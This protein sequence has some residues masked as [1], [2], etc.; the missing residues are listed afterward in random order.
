MTVNVSDLVL[1]DSEPTSETDLWE[2]ASVFVADWT[3]PVELTNS[4]TTVIHESRTA[5]E[6]RIGLSNKPRK[7][8][9]SQNKIF[10]SGDVSDIKTIMRRV[11]ESR[12]LTPM[13]CDPCQL[14]GI[15]NPQSA[16]GPTW[17]IENAT[18]SRISK[19]GWG[20]LGKK[21]N[22]TQFS[23]YAFCGDFDVNESAGSIQFCNDDGGCC[24]GDMFDGITY[25]QPSVSHSGYSTLTAIPTSGF[26][27]SATMDTS[28][29]VP[30]NGDH[31]ILILNYL[32]KRGESLSTG[33]MQLVDSNGRTVLGPD[34][35]VLQEIGGSS[36]YEA[37]SQIDATRNL[38]V[39]IYKATIHSDRH[40]ST[41]G[42]TWAA[43]LEPTYSGGGASWLTMDVLVIPASDVDTQEPFPY[44]AFDEARY[45][46]RSSSQAAFSTN[47]TARVTGETF[48]DCVT[49]QA[50]TAD[51]YW[52]ADD[53][54]YSAYGVSHGFSVTGFPDQSGD[55]SGG[56][57]TNFQ[58]ARDML[59]ARHTGAY[60]SAALFTARLVE[61]G[62]NPTERFRE[63]LFVRIRINPSTQT[64][65]YILYPAMET[66]MSFQMGADVVTREI[67]VMLS[68]NN[69]TI[70]QEGV[71]PLVDIG[72]TPTGYQTVS[73]V[74][75]GGNEIICPV[76]ERS[77]DFE[78]ARY[79]VGRV[80]D[81]SQVGI[82]RE[83]HAYGLHRTTFDMSYTFLNRADAF[84]F[85]RLFQSRGGRLHPFFQVPATTEFSVVAV[86]I[87]GAKTATVN[88]GNLLDD[89]L[90]DMV[91][92]YLSV[93][94]G[95][96]YQITE[97]LGW[98]RDPDNTSNVILNLSDDFGSEFLTISS[99]R[100]AGI[101][102]LCR[103]GQDSLMESWI[104]SQVMKC[105]ITSIE[106]IGE[107][108]VSM[109]KPAA[110]QRGIA[111]A[112]MFCGN[113]GAIGVCPSC[114]GPSDTECGCPQERTMACGYKG[115]GRTCGP[116]PVLWG[117]DCS[118]DD[119]FNPPYGTDSGGGS[120]VSAFCNICQP[121]IEVTV[122][123]TKHCCGIDW[124]YPCPPG[125][126]PEDPYVACN[127]MTAH[128][129]FT[130]EA[131]Y[132]ACASHAYEATS[133][134]PWEEESETCYDDLQNLIESEVTGWSPNLKGSPL[135]YVA[136]NVPGE[137]SHNVGFA[138]K[139]GFVCDDMQEK[140]FIGSSEP[141][142]PETGQ[143]FC[144]WDELSNGLGYP[145][146][147]HGSRRWSTYSSAYGD[148]WMTQTG[149]RNALWGVDG[150]GGV[151][152]HCGCNDGQ[153]ASDCTC[154]SAPI[155]VGCSSCSGRADMDSCDGLKVMAWQPTNLIGCCRQSCP[156]DDC[157]YVLQPKLS[158]QIKTGGNG[159]QMPVIDPID[160]DEFN[161]Q[162]WPATKQ[163]GG[164][165]DGCRDFDNTN[166]CG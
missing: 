95:S 140:P 24:F 166:W 71:D 161:G 58:F 82:G 131:E 72:V 126:D 45:W 70:G 124:D 159:G 150:C 63:G 25:G 44:G 98:S 97:I 130:F 41:I 99:L 78:S 73:Y 48:I 90:N 136:K 162:S 87:G 33:N 92:R 50:S 1:R 133:T 6:A 14:I 103:F 129:C 9:V 79:S 37:Q 66:D 134:Y 91:G 47:F 32:I 142:N 112:Q 11:G 117:P 38:N 116:N 77:P 53:T 3:L 154:G 12:T 121:T 153:W 10:D 85:L 96:D 143:P 105:Q 69:E 160:G 165:P 148:S 125:N 76:L 106:I 101:A 88:N 151:A 127:T 100:R 64:S 67:S 80:G 163:G 49:A 146:R 75:P 156:P 139:T 93:F 15:N 60:N 138:V 18:D 55:T 158:F 137:S 59:L 157:W 28:A 61:D 42:G 68:E 2:P 113:A 104:T 17:N 84:K 40:T 21:Q 155:F 102:H 52:D 43:K 132:L 94:N 128:C 16:S 110:V 109:Q 36:K 74:E 120:G 57:S 20:M 34:G 115:D 108:Y 23:E 30:S 29:S 145:A 39:A 147:T 111:C 141:I 123:H 81:E 118:E 51:D 19:S 164:C 8:L 54:E 31:V 149:V 35:F 114:S 4:Y 135:I 107:Q 152:G 46:A 122:C 65:G 22:G 119:M 56:P 5:K 86:G 62:S 27:A 144:N 13:L 7:T 26:T 89:A 83:S